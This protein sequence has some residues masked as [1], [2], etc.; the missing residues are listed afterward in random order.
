MREGLD[1]IA[2]TSSYE[3]EIRAQTLR[4]TPTG[5][6]GRRGLE[7]PPCPRLDRA[8]PW[9]VGVIPGVSAPEDECHPQAWAGAGDGEGAG[10]G[11]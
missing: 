10:E 4:G 3:E 8:R 6:T 1:L 5:D 9:A 7:E 11:S 2:L